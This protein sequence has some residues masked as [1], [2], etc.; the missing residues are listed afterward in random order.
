MTPRI[1]IIFSER[2]RTVLYALPAVLWLAS[3]LYIVLTQFQALPPGFTSASPVSARNIAVLGMC[4]LLMYP[5]YRLGYLALGRVFPEWPQIRIMAVLSLGCV[6][7]GGLALV[8]TYLLF[9]AAN[10]PLTQ[11]DG[12]WYLLNLVV[13]MFLMPVFFFLMRGTAA[14]REQ[15]SSVSRMG[16]IKALLR[17][18][19]PDVG[20]KLV[21]LQSADHYVEVHTETGAKLLLMRLGDAVDLLT[22]SNGQQVHRSHWVNLEE[23]K[24]VIKRNRKIWLRMSDGTDVPVSRSFSPAL[25]EA[26]II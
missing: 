5:V 21:R 17:R 25:R 20:Q 12:R 19:G 13:G 2:D 22:G 16:A 15:I 8:V 7:V 10:G 18:L 26:G 9:D 6:A 1:K 24:G 23:V 4:F 3:C 14:V 11:L